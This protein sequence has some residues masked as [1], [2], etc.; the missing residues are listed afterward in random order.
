[1]YL[2]LGTEAFLGIGMNM[3][4]C[5]MCEWDMKP[6]PNFPSISFMCLSCANILFFDFVILLF[7]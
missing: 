4:V 6:V 5:D 1:M 2:C 3:N 7:H